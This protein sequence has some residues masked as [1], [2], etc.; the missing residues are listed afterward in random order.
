ME[1]GEDMHLDSLIDKE[2]VCMEDAM[3]PPLTREV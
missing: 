2:V 1:D 3:Q